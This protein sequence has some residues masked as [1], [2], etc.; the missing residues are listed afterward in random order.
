MSQD[1]TVQPAEVQLITSDHNGIKYQFNTKNERRG[2]KVVRSTDGFRYIQSKMI[3]NGVYLKCAIFRNW[4][5][6]TAKLNLTR[7]LITAMI[8]ISRKF[9]EFPLSEVIFP[10]PRAEGP[11]TSKSE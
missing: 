9:L 3:E 8:Y 4:C 10:L 11:S 7:N 2:S 1:K 5:K 6:G